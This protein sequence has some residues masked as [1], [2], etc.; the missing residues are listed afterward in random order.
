MI[1]AEEQ[2]QR[3]AAL[4]ALL[5]KPLLVADAD[6]DQQRLSQQGTQR[7]AALRLFLGRDHDAL[8]E[9]GP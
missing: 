7:R 3:R 8:I 5:A 6:G 2:A 1:P 4:R 9:R